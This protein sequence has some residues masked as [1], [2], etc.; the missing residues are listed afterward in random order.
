[1]QLAAKDKS[2]YKRPFKMMSLCHSLKISALVHGVSLKAACLCIAEYGRNYRDISV[3][4][5]SNYPAQRL[6]S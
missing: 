5:G 1:M 3:Q 2:V 6:R 4:G